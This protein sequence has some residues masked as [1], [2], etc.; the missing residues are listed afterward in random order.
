MNKCGLESCKSIC[1]NETK[2][3]KKHQIHIFLD[4]TKSLNKRPCKNY[5]RDCRA[6]LDDTYTKKKC[7]EHSQG[8]QKKGRK[9]VRKPQKNYRRGP[10]I[11][12]FHLIDWRNSREAPIR[13]G[14]K[15]R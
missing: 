7:E 8:S 5:I 11:G 14:P 3:C 4:E 10:Y 6:Q 12:R 15:P 2:Y 13:I 1:I 9:R